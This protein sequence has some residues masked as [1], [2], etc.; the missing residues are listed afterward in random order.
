MENYKRL[1]S[2]AIGKPQIIRLWDVFFLAP[3]MIYTGAR[4]SNLPGSMRLIMVVSGVLTAVYNGRNYLIQRQMEKELNE[5]PPETGASKPYARLL[6]YR[7]KA[8]P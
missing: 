8:G 6:G 7:Q 2:V 4:K 3:L 1:K 5:A